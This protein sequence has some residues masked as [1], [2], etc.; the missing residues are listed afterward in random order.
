[1]ELRDP[2]GV[3]SLIGNASY[4]LGHGQSHAF[5][6]R[7][8]PLSEGEFA[9]TLAFSG[10]PKGTQ[11][12]AVKGIGLPPKGLFG[13]GA[14]APAGTVPWGNLLVVGAALGFLLAGRKPRIPA[15]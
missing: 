4:D 6:V 14:G 13:C 9:A 3:F 8:S 7:F 1:V 15:R 11:I 10:D 12:A 2:A 5:I